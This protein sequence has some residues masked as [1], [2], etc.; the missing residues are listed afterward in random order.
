MQARGTRRS[1][2]GGEVLAC[3]LG[4]SMG[5]AAGAQQT[6]N[7]FDNG[8]V[9]LIAKTN[10]GVQEPSI[11]LYLGG[12]RVNDPMTVGADAFDL[13]DFQDRV[14]GTSS[15][16]LTMADIIA[17]GYIRP[18]VQRSDGLTGA[19]GTSIVTGPS[20]RPQFQVLD[21]IPDMTRADVTTGG[22]VRVEVQGTGSYGSRATLVCR[23]AYP[24]PEIGRTVALIEYTWTATQNITMPSVASGRGNDA[25]RFV[26]FSSMLASTAGGVYD[27]RYI[28]VTDTL[29]RRRTLEVSDEIRNGYLFATPRATGVGRAFA[30][31]KDNAATWNPG[32]PSIEIEVV[33]IS[34]TGASVGAIGVQGYRADTTDP[35]DDSLSVWL[36]WMDVP[37]VIAVGTTLSVSLR[38]IAAPATD[39]GDLNHDGAR[40][41]VDVGLLDGQMGRMPS[42]ALFDAY[43]DLDRD[44]VVTMN[45]RAM[46]LGS[47][48]EVSS[49]F[50]MSGESNSQDF[51]DFL[52]AFFVGEADFNG[53]G[54]TDS[55]DLFD[56]VSAFFL[57]C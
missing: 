20:F 7:F 26:M 48:D 25:F 21:I 47:L 6:Y 15:Y 17:N 19:I 1:A 23:R 4:V 52:N 54:A 43:A 36:E 33:S 9:A 12:V 32:S 24:D 27:A 31:L 18:L 37:A 34:G 40:D 51:F 44:G 49:D 30:L 42:D 13:I 35:N 56:F 22:S 39:P 50:N 41:C 28:G 55:Q 14:P 53:S 16:P 2:L 45:D 3:V 10:A 57:G 11:P 29:G 5:C 46:L 8:E 38:V